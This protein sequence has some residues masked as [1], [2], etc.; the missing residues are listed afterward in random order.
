MRIEA[1]QHSLNGTI[2]KIALAH[3]LHVGL[4][5]DIKNLAE[6]AD[7]I[8]LACLGRLPGVLRSLGFLCGCSCRPAKKTDARFLLIGK[9]GVRTGTK[10]SEN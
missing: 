5:N 6:T 1:L 8:E 9:P 3:F 10:G 2:D 4:L 7:R